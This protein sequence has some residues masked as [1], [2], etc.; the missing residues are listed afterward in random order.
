MEHS[1]RAPVRVNHFTAYDLGCFYGNLPYGIDKE[2]HVKADE[3]NRANC[4][5][6]SAPPYEPSLERSFRIEDC[7]ESE[8]RFLDRITNFGQYG[9]LHSDPHIK[10]RNQ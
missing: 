8:S 7:P 5:A 3:A 9:I 2:S 10:S 6:Q 4:P 1:H